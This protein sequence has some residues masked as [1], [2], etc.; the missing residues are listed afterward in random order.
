ML[1]VTCVEFRQGKAD[2][3]ESLERVSARKRMASF[4]RLIEL[5]AAAR[6]VSDA[7]RLDD[8]RPDMNY[9]TQPASGYGMAFRASSWPMLL[10][11]H[12][13]LTRAPF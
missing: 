7:Q 8:K 9:A 3:R 1:D 5:R 4:E 6:D 11:A 13:K 12:R 10:S 2:K